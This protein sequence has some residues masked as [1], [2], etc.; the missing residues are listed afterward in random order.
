MIWTCPRKI[1]ASGLLTV[2]LTTT[3]D[4]ARDVRAAAALGTG[5][6][7]AAVPV[8]AAGRARGE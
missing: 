2:N 3:A 7:P 4:A 8:P 5:P 6:T 1:P